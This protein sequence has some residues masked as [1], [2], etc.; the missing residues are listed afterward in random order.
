MVQ[1]RNL[2]SIQDTF[3]L[4]CSFCFVTFVM[5]SNAG[6]HRITPSS[7]CSREAYDRVAESLSQA[8]TNKGLDLGAPIF[9]RIFKESEELE[10][11][12]KQDDRFSLF[13]TYTIC[14]YSG[15]LGPKQSE[16]DKQSPEGFYTVGIDQMNPWSNFHLSFNL[17]FPNTYDL[18]HQRTGS[19]LMVHGRCSSVGC[20]AMTDFRMDEIYILADA[21]LAN[22]QET[23][24]VHIFPF[25]MTENNLHRYSNSKWLSFWINLKEGYDL[26][27]H[28]RVPPEITVKNNRYSFSLKN[29]RLVTQSREKQHGNS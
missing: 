2:H 1:F 3:L 7:K 6:A 10:L 24:D 11:W 12:V 8:M 16:G 9:I 4:I 21:A 22:G 13:N 28:H 20:F 19:A 29:Y 14:E 26:F 23:F 17:G 5:V 27:Q 25:R 18:N 15:E